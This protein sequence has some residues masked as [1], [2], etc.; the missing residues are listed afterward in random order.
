MH[1]TIEATQD[2]KEENTFREFIRQYLIKEWH[3]NQEKEDFKSQF[4]VMDPIEIAF[5]NCLTV[6]IVE[7]IK[8]NTIISINF[9]WFV[10]VED[11]WRNIKYKHVFI[12]TQVLA[13]IILCLN[14]YKL[15][16]LIFQFYS[17]NFHVW[18]SII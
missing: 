8:W 16:S 5:M 1:E 17:E 11:F 4:V 3:N 13:F 2:W 18:K 6:Y 15:C 9:L 7:I 14:F 10:F 12:F